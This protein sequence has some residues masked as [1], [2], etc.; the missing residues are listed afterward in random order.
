MLFNKIKGDWLT[1]IKNLLL[2]LSGTAILA[3][4]TAVFIVPFDLVSGGVS[5][6]A[7]VINH[8]LKIEWLTIDMIVTA[9][10]WIF[11]ALGLVLLGKDFAI[12]TLLSTL[13]YPILF[14]LFL[15]LASPD[16]LSGYFYLL[17]SE[18]QQISMMIATVVGGAL[19]GIGCAVA[20]L[21]GGSTGGVDVIAFV[22]AKLFPRVKSSVMIFVIDAT[23]VL[24][25][26]LVIQDLVISILGVITAL[27]AALF[28][29]KV[30][31]GG[32]KSFVAHIVSD[33]HEEICRAVIER[34][35]RT[36]TVIEGVGAYSG[37]TKKVIMVSFAM[38]QYAELIKIVN[39]VDKDAFITINKA[40]EI[41]G[42]GWTR[43]KT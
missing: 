6:I 29:D 30:F 21:G 40:H 22:L 42:E 35:D 23:I 18:N 25:G 38:S 13:A 26:V 10:T 4:G 1:K 5:G 19:I 17:G 27:I 31:L 15:K 7:I 32:T 8:I 16:V 39:S 24:A 43:E 2:V 12:K 37:A 34:M 33:S 9:L 20:F 11:F 3:F 36:A 14:S 41:N 28:V